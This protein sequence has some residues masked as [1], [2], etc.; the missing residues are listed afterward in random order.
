MEVMVRS[1]Y[2]FS[3]GG[4]GKKATDDFFFNFLGAELVFNF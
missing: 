3:F 2:N 4:G 1:I